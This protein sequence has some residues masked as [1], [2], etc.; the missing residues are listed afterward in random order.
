MSNVFYGDITEKALGIENARQL[1]RF[2]TQWSINT[3]KII[4]S[5]IESQANTLYNV[6]WRNIKVKI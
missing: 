3:S 6:K 5:Y 2:Y 1:K 4:K